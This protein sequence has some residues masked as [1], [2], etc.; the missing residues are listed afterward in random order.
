MS[1]VQ[2][3]VTGRPP[4]TSHAQIEAVS[5]HLFATQG[6]EET[7]MEEIAAALDV[8]RRTLFRYFPSKNDIPWGQF[9]ASL[10]NFRQTLLDQPNHIPLF[11]AV[12][13]A[14][15]AFNRFDDEALPQHRQ[16]MTLILRTPALQAHSVLRYRQWRAV[17]A[18]YVADRLKVP[19]SSLVPRMVGQVSLAIALSVYEQWLDGDDRTLEEIFNLTDF[20]LREYA[21]PSEGNR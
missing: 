10:A 21:D 20:A 11:E 18:D 19:A 5:F 8:G 13:R 14:M 12:H 2:K 16:R 7:T 1:A 17:I 15:I 6:F 4:V 3:P 9:D